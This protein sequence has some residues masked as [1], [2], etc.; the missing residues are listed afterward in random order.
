MVLALRIPIK[1]PPFSSS[2]FVTHEGENVGLLP[3]G[4]MTSI[5]ASTEEAYSVDKKTDCTSGDLSS[6]PGNG[7]VFL[8]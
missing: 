2:S 6:V 5:L 7:W 1:P 4:M 3:L 8:G